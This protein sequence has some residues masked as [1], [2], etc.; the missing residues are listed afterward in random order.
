[1]CALYSVGRKLIL[2]KGLWK[3][4]RQRGVPVSVRTAF[5]AKGETGSDVPWCSLSP[6]PGTE[7]ARECLG[8]AGLA[9]LLL[10]A[11]LTFILGSLMDM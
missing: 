7:E 11:E 5:S 9:S 4:H 2:F 3:S 6:M 1:M 8:L 10:H